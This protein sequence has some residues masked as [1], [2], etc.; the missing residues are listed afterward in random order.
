MELTEK[1]RPQTLSDVIGQNHY[2]IPLSNIAKKIAA[3]EGDGNCPHIGL[4][5]RPGFGKTATAKAFCRDAFGQEWKTNFLS[6]NASDKRG[7]DVVRDTMIEFARRMVI[8]ELICGKKIPFSVVHL[9]EFDMLTSEAQHALR[10]PLERYSKQCRF[11]VTANEPGRIIEPVLDRFACKS[12][13]FLPVKPEDSI[14]F[15]KRI[16]EQEKIDI[17]PNA[18]GMISSPVI[19]KGSVRSQLK[20]L[21]WLRNLGRRITA[22]DVTRSVS[23]VEVTIDTN[24]VE[25]AMISNERGTFPYSILKA[26][27]DLY[28]SSGCGEHEIFMAIVGAIDRSTKIQPQR[29]REAL[30]KLANGALMLERSTGTDVLKL[31]VRIM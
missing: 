3:G 1:Y 6:L 11:I 31:L 5:G 15:L 16:C 18:I 30:V 13:R 26:I 27:D 17:D 4:F 14:P 24:V 22:Q 12:M 21:D 29:K 20:L 8:G 2:T 10:E 28:F 7:I 23:N 9:D 25:E 19:S